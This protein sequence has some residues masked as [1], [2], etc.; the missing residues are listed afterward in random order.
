[1]GTLSRIG[2]IIG[3][4]SLLRELAFSARPFGA[5]EAAKMGFVSR[6][7]QGGHSDVVDAALALARIIA[8]RCL[9]VTD[10]AGGAKLTV[11]TRQ[12]S[13]SCS[14]DKASAEL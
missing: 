7:V 14:R 4:D 8:S 2:K 12:I 11:S 6:V 5:E 10:A 9:I 3:N 1:M 13:R